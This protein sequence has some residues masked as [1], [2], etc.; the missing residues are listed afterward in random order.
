MSFR[1][2]SFQLGLSLALLV[3]G[4]PLT[5]NSPSQN[6]DQIKAAGCLV[7]SRS[8][9]L[10]NVNRYSNTLQL[11]IGKQHPGE[12]AW[13]TAVRET[14]EETGFSVEVNYQIH[15]FSKYALLFDCTVIKSP[16]TILS[17]QDTLEVSDV[18]FLNPDT[19]TMSNGEIT[20][21]NWRYKTTAEFLKSYLELPMII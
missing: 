19:M 2:F 12:Y 8:G 16:H 11:P 21:L 3:S 20:K 4:L 6:P 7:K 9:V 13:Q 5:I 14:F 15:G 17:P 18:F 1:R 10:V